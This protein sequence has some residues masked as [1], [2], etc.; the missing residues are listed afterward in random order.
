[1]QTRL[2]P[3][4]KLLAM[5]CVW[6][7]RP[8]V[9]K[10][11]EDLSS[12]VSS[13]PRFEQL[14]DHHRVRPLAN[15]AITRTGIALPESTKTRLSEAALSSSARALTMARETVRIADLLSAHNLGPLVIKGAALAQLCYQ[16][17]ALKESWDIDLL[18]RPNETDL[19]RELLFDAGYTVMRPA[20]TS[21][22]FARFVPLTKEIE[23]FNPEAGVTI[24][25]HWRLI[26]GRGK[27]NA[28]LPSRPT[29]RVSMQFGHLETLDD[30]RMFSY[31]C[32][33]GA[34]HNWFRLKWLADLNAFIERFPADARSG[35]VDSARKYGAERSV[36]IALALCAQLFGLKSPRREIFSSNR[37]L[38][39][40]LLERN[41][42]ETLG[43]SGPLEGVKANRSLWRR[44]IFASFFVV[45]GFAHLRE[46]AWHYWQSAGDHAAIDLPNRLRFGYH[47]LR[48]P[49][50]IGRWSK[51]KMANNLTRR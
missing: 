27:L 22:Q 31:L 24:E 20:L 19:A 14:T 32:L 6:P 30:E 1:M 28:A 8:V 34:T 43:F 50:L 18:V 49:L 51:R 38:V 21:A 23:F 46:T 4:L 13:W 41:V 37:D 45:P 48:L 3:E 16:S 40:R 11:I 44:S 47:L 5:C 2:P 17:L 39:S 26:N 25:L 33:H 9:D 12:R 42:I 7:P 36:S 15:A 35:L 10:R 29:Q